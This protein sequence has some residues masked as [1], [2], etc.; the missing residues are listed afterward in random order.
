[1][2]YFVRWPQYNL[3]AESFDGRPIG[4]GKIYMHIFI[5]K[6]KWS[7]FSNNVVVYEDNDSYGK[8]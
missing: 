1:M 6:I 7:I 4:Y 2:K 8:E 5:I 3:I